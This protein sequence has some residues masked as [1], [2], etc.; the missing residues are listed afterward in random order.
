LHLL[1]HI[2]KL[3]QMAMTRKVL[4]TAIR[5]R[6]FARP[7]LA[8]SLHNLFVGMDSQVELAAI[9]T[10]GGLKCSGQNDG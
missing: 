1:Q 7:T 4:H 9:F 3:P 2:S 10:Q 6:L 8:E 5:K